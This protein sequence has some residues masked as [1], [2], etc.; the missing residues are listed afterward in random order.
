MSVGNRHTGG[1]ETLLSDKGSPSGDLDRV[2]RSELQQSWGTKRLV[3]SDVDVEKFG[4]P[5]SKTAMFDIESGSNTRESWSRNLLGTSIVEP[6]V[7]STFQYGG[8]DYGTSELEPVA[9]KK[10]DEPV[11]ANV[12]VGSAEN[13][14]LYSGNET[15]SGHGTGRTK[16]D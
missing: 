13:F 7:P 8:T 6:C 14:S 16:Y 15:Q 11:G 12:C 9:R 1:H 3:S 10:A 4:L 2:L 5:P